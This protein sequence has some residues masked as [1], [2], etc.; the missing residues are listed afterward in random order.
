MKELNKE[1]MLKEIAEY[2]VTEEDIRR[3]YEYE[4]NESDQ[5]KDYENVSFEEY[6]KAYYLSDKY[7]VEKELEEG[8]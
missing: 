5:A 7:I 3:D 8:F 4:K 1:E 2:G 6:L